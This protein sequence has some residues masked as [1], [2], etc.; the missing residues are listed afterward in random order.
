MSI[1]AAQNATSSKVGFNSDMVLRKIRFARTLIVG[2]LP[3]S[4]LLILKIK[5]RIGADDAAPLAGHKV[6]A[7]KAVRLS[8]AAFPYAGPVVLWQKAFGWW[9]RSL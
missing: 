9:F 4:K 8:A 7:P 2:F 5:Q 6:T 1:E 3:S